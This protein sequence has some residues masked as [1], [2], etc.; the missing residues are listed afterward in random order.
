MRVNWVVNEIMRPI[1][2]VIIGMIFYLLGTGIILSLCAYYNIAFPLYLW[3]IDANNITEAE[4]EKYWREIEKSVAILK[5]IIIPSISVIIGF[6]VGLLT[7]KKALLLGVI[8]S[9]SYSIIAFCG[10]I[11]GGISYN[12]LTVKLIFYF[13][14]LP[15]FLC[16]LSSHLSYK[17]KI[18][19]KKKIIKIK[20]V[21]T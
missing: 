18:W 11:S 20:K 19:F 15:I 13:C 4:A 9:L 6:I 3:Q 5:F 7:N 8:V 21:R 17:L 12:L 2:V 10:I 1:I 14:L 16:S